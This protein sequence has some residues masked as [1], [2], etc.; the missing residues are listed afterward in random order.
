[1]VEQW[2]PFQALE[3]ERGKGIRVQRAIL[4]RSGKKIFVLV[5]VEE[6]KRGD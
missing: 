3:A 5:K 6:E 4:D 2:A 1:M